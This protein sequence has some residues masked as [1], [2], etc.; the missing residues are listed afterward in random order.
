M[1]IKLILHKQ[2]NVDENSV[3]RQRIKDVT[4]NNTL[5]R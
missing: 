5:L 2:I 1:I 3:D 4:R